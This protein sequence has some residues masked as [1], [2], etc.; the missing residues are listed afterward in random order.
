MSGTRARGRYNGATAAAA[1]RG[2][3]GMPANG[4]PA[5]RPDALPGPRPPEMANPMRNQ[6]TTVVPVLLSNT[7][8]QQMATL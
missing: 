6:K 2:R 4:A 5:L 1:A 7:I 8:P 3:T